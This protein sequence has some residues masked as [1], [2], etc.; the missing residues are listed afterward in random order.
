MNYDE[1]LEQY[2]YEYEDLIFAWDNKPD[3]NF[4]DRVKVIAK[5]YHDNFDKIV[6]FIKSN[7]EDIYENC[8]VISLT[9][10]ALRTQCR[11]C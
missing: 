2:I 6:L 10:E 1:S 7:I 8:F 5:N 3:D 4:E 11:Q 9:R